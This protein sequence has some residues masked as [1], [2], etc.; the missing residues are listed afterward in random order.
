MFESSEA[1]KSKSS[2]I[3]FFSFYENLL[4]D[5]N[6]SISE[7]FIQIFRL[8][9]Q[10]LKDSKEKSILLTEV[11]FEKSSKFYQFV[12]S[13]YFA[14]QEKI[15]S[16]VE[17]NSK[18]F[19]KFV[20]SKLSLQTF[21][22]ASLFAFI[23]LLNLVGVRS[24]KPRFPNPSNP[25]GSFASMTSRFGQDIYVNR[26]N[27]ENES[28]SS[29]IV[30]APATGINNERSFVLKQPRPNPRNVILSASRS[31]KG[32]VTYNQS[33][34]SQK[35]DK[36]FVLGKLS[37]ANLSS[38]ECIELLKNHIQNKFPGSVVTIRS[39]YGLIDNV[40]Q[41]LNEI[42]VTG[43]VSQFGRLDRIK[44]ELI[45]GVKETDGTLIFSSFKTLDR[46]HTLNSFTRKLLNISTD[47]ASAVFVE[48]YLHSRIG[49]NRTYSLPIGLGYTPGTG[50]SL[51]LIEHL[52]EQ[53]MAN[54]LKI[55]NDREV[56]EVLNSI[57]LTPEELQ[58][59]YSRA[60]Q[61]DSNLIRS[62]LENSIDEN[63]H[64]AES[65]DNY[66]NEETAKEFVSLR[67]RL[68]GNSK[69]F[70]SK[71]GEAVTEIIEDAL[72]RRAHNHTVKDLLTKN[73]VPYNNVVQNQ[74]QVVSEAKRLI[75]FVEACGGKVDRTIT[76]QYTNETSSN[77][78]PPDQ[79]FTEIL[80]S[81]Q[82]TDLKKPLTSLA[83]PTRFLDNY[84]K[85]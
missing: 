8:F 49:Q 23:A 35:N 38:D 50:G 62:R 27:R 71:A 19:T 51:T 79:A 10:F 65:F 59:V 45:R 68:S 81:Q 54:I 72:P 20:Q 11:S 67:K 4:N 46:D 34:R 29:M 18:F 6:N 63:M 37:F 31:S 60:F 56:V 1:V 33:T 75:D 47:R 24:S 9:E 12:K 22:I 57:Q 77:V 85:E 69:Q 84:P 42:S 41:E 30:A 32:L 48:Q 5:S 13:F 16:I 3:V 44:K 76:D 78:K 36:K 40:Y 43:T 25:A 73:T 83:G 15:Q 14:Y 39:T 7:D 64:L 28:G 82:I 55:S 17:E 2:E 58:V 66:L 52:R 74:E 21:I 80:E 70:I 61:L 53:D 26:T